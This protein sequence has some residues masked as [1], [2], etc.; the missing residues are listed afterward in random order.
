[1]AEELKTEI[2]T[3]GAAD[4]QVVFQSQQDFDAVISR[5]LEQDR[6]KY[7][8]YDTVKSDLETL[9]KEKQEREDSE[10]SEVEKLTDANTGLQ[11]KVDELNKNI[12]VYADGEKQRNAVVM[13]K[14]D[15]AV[16][17]LTDEEKDLV[18]AQSTPDLKLNLA[19]MFGKKEPPKPPSG[20]KSTMPATTYSL[21]QL[22]ELKTTNP[23]LWRSEYGKYRAQIGRR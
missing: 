20:G 9:T 19:G 21:E 13:L 16:K 5:R 17:D 18:N 3:S 4:G 2:P 23:P 8:D 14:V 7:A 6:K 15:E 11:A 22:N 1:M 12:D 10:K